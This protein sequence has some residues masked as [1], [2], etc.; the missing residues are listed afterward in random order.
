M[1]R[2]ADA[3]I[4]HSAPSF[5]ILLVHGFRTACHNGMVDVCDG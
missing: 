1:S 4:L 3:L 5:V 2:F